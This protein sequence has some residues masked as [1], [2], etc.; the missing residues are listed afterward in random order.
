MELYKVI[1]NA[2]HNVSQ[3]QGVFKC[4]HHDGS[5]KSTSASSV[6]SRSLRSYP[7]A[8]VGWA[9]YKAMTIQVLCAMTK[10]SLKKS[11]KKLTANLH[12]LDSHPNGNRNKLS[13]PI[14]FQPQ[15]SPISSWRCLTAVILAHYNLK[16]FNLKLMGLLDCIFTFKCLQPFCEFL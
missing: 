9:Y 3:T 15:Y 7:G 6:T 8:I 4:E 11:E 5:D 14:I 10:N 13:R 1:N 12:K 16:L 2:G